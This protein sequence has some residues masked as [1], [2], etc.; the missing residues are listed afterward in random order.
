M[1]LRAFFRRDSLLGRHPAIDRD[2]LAGDV[3]GP[4]TGQEH[5]C[6]G[7]VVSLAQTIGRDA[8]PDFLQSLIPQRPGHI[9]LDKAWCDGIDGNFSLAQFSR[10]TA[11]QADHPRFG[12]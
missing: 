11:S 5:Y 8:F 9:A 3:A 4:G 1:A 7:D 2:Y 12:G 6:S 10:Q